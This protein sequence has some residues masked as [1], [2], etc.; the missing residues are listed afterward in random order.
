L[1]WRIIIFVVCRNLAATVAAELRAFVKLSIPVY[2][3]V[4]FNALSASAV[5]NSEG[6]LLSA[7]TKMWF[8]LM[9]L[10]PFNGHLLGHPLLCPT[11]RGEIEN[12]QTFPTTH[13]ITA[14]LDILRDEGQFYVKYLQENGVSVT[15]TLYNNTPHGFFA[16]SVFPHGREALFDVCD[17]IKSFFGT[18]NI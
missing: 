10:G 17:L 18:A 12:P 13:V 2:P 16:S 9:H 7:S 15:H 6:I 4:T 3:C 11:S 14:E 8:D 5:E 1:G